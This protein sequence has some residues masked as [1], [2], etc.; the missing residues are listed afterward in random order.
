MLG[1]GD[2]TLQSAIY[3]NIGISPAG[4]IVGQFNGDG[5]TDLTLSEGSNSSVGVALVILAPILSV[6]SEHAA[7]FYFGETGDALPLRTEL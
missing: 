2:G 1:N 5:R 3:Y 4:M 7:R 6:T